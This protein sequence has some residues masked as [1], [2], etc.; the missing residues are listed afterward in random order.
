MHSLPGERRTNQPERTLPP[1]APGPAPPFLLGRLDLLAARRDEVPPDIARTTERRAAERH[2]PGA[3]R[4]GG[5]GDAVAGA[6]TNAGEEVGHLVGPLGDLAEGELGLA[7]VAAHHPQR[8]P[9]VVAGVDVEPVERPGEG[10]ELRPA[11]PG[12]LYRQ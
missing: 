10:L 12:A 7:R 6:D 2:Q 9:V 11:E 5:H 4:A 3:G 8:G 1:L